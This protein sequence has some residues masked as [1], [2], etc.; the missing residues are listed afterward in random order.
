VED[1][2]VK[3]RRNAQSD[4]LL[5]D[6]FGAPVCIDRENRR[7]DPKIAM[8]TTTLLQAQ[9]FEHMTAA[10]ADSAPPWAAKCTSDHRFEPT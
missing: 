6:V 3:P 2:G 8:A 9:R 7:F 1:K 10:A 4:P 5:K